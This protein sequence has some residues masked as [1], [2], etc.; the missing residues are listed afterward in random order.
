MFI[1]SSYSFCISIVPPLTRGMTLEGISL[2]TLFS[3][4]TSSSEILE[5]EFFSLGGSYPS[6]S[7]FSASEIIIF[8]FNNLSDTYS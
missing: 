4:G 2:I 3:L 1:F 6:E 5:F 8:K 7:L